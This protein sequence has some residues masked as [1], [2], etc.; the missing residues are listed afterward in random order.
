LACVACLETQK[1]WRFSIV[2]DTNMILTLGK[3]IIAAAWADGEVSP[4][5]VNSLKDLLFHLPGLTGRE[6]ANLEMYIESPVGEA[7][8]ARLV[9]QLTEQISSGSDKTLALHALD[10]LVSA[11]GVIT[12]SSRPGWACSARWER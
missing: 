4:E 5:E 3:V 10:G 8:R 1:G 11:D 6:W 2:I 12:R 9:I 7:E